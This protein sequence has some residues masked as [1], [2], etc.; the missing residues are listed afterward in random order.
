MEE[1]EGDLEKVEGARKEE[2]EE[3]KGMRSGIRRKGIR[4][5]NY[6]S[7]SLFV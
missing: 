3:A 4:V 5:G 2:E 7:T 1:D 6:I